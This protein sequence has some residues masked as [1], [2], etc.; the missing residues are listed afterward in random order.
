MLDGTGKIRLGRAPGRIIRDH[1]RDLAST[2]M[3]SVRGVVYAWYRIRKVNSNDN[4]LKYVPY[5]HFSAFARKTDNT[6]VIRGLAGGNCCG[7]QKFF[8]LILMQ[9]YDG[10]VKAND[11]S[12]LSY[13]FDN[14]HSTLI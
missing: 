8:G 6:K 4:A 5:N 2:V 10:K 1:V 7:G 14:D 11:A 9:F 13:A 12:Y 3:I